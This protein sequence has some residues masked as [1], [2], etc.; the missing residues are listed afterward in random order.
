MSHGRLC[1][2]A[3]SWLFATVVSAAAI[4][5]AAL[6]SATIAV[7]PEV[8]EWRRDFH[9]NPE[10]SNREF[11]TS[12]KV[13]E[14]LRALGIEVRTGIAHTGV[15]GILRGGKPGPTIALRADM[16]AL[17]GG[18]TRRP[19]VQVAGNGRISR[20]ES[21]RHACLWP[22]RPHGDTA[23][24]GQGARRHAQGV[25]GHGHVHLPAGRR[26]RAGRRARRC[27]AD[28]RRGRARQSAARSDLRSAPVFDARPSARRLSVRSADGGGRT[29]SGSSC[30]AS[31]RMARGPGSASIRS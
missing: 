29:S 3:S 31:R 19:A 4:D 22:R 25:A 10:L 11:R 9:R 17:A 20:P 14:E 12:K 13:A 23:R 2:A 21:R 18:R 5:R 24:R 28:D 6:E 27:A 26:R 30:A 15:V 1:C 16:D 8:V 7:V